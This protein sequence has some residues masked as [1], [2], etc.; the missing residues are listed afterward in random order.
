MKADVLITLLVI[1]I[2]VV[3]GFLGVFIIGQVFGSDIERYFQST[4]TGCGRE[5]QECCPQKWCDAGLEC[6]E[7]NIC[8]EKFGYEAGPSNIYLIYNST[9]FFNSSQR[10]DFFYLKTGLGGEDCSNAINCINCTK[11][12]HFSNAL[13]CT[14]CDYCNITDNTCED[15]FVCDSAEGGN[16]QELFDCYDC[17]GCNVDIS[18]YMADSCSQCSFCNG[19]NISTYENGLSCS[20]C[21]GCEPNVGDDCYFCYECGGSEYKVCEK[22]ERIAATTCEITSD[23]ELCQAAK[24]EVMLFDGGGEPIES[25][26][27]VPWETTYSFYT[28]VSNVL[29]NCP[30]TGDLKKFIAE[31]GRQKICEYENSNFVERYFESDDTAY[32]PADLIR[33]ITS[34]SITGENKKGILFNSCGPPPLPEEYIMGKCIDTDGGYNNLV[35]GTCKD[36]ST[37]INGCTDYCN[38]NAIVE[39]VCEFDD[40]IPLLPEPPCPAVEPLNPSCVD[41]ACVGALGTIYHNDPQIFGSS[42]TT[43]KTPEDDVPVNLQIVISDV[44]WNENSTNDCSYNVH[45]CSQEALAESED[46]AILG[47]WNLSAY[48]D[49][50]AYEVEINEWPPFDL[51]DPIFEDVQINV[52]AFRYRPTFKIYV[53]ANYDVQHIAKAIVAGLRDYMIYNSFNNKTVEFFCTNNNLHPNLETCVQNDVSVHLNDKV[54]WNLESFAST[55]DT[56]ASIPVYKNI[57]YNSTKTS[58]SNEEVPIQITFFAYTTNYSFNY[59]NENLSRK[60]LVSPVIVIGRNRAAAPTG[61]SFVWDCSNWDEGDKHDFY[62][63]TC[64]GDEPYAI[65]CVSENYYPTQSTDEGDYGEDLIQKIKIRNDESCVVRSRDTS[66]GNEQGRRVCVLCSNRTPSIVWGL[67][68]PYDQDWYTTTWEVG[69]PWYMSVESKECPSGHYPISCL[70]DIDELDPNRGDE[71]D[72]VVL[73]DLY[74]EDNKCKGTFRDLYGDGPW[75]NKGGYHW[76][77]IT[78]G[79]VCF[80]E[81][82]GTPK[83]TGYVSKDEGTGPSE[84]WPLTISGHPIQNFSSLECNAAEFP[85]SVFSRV[86]SSDAGAYTED[87]LQSTYLDGQRFN[88]SARDIGHCPWHSPWCDW[89]EQKRDVGVLC[90]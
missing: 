33:M 45:I 6:S 54:S 30:V 55:V 5:G 34:G 82:L 75:F 16:Y 74:L 59:N 85:V 36:E 66:G 78:L 44:L 84:I 23:Y 13:T 80:D 67:T 1:F 47:F 77:R 79:I 65:S 39:Y 48:F 32:V 56:L 38:G 50:N 69:E 14:D 72:E 64:S 20:Y 87:I 8:V 53:N 21:N 24:E 35:K 49:L 63:P 11:L 71:F 9:E 27:P 4:F 18:N 41:G 40:C 31:G 29:G 52:T 88:V 19:A 61:L 42:G 51:I 17:G 68:S 57:Y 83:W 15:C 86:D 73:T 58:Y 81:Y 10:E 89:T 28:T 25:F 70:A 26:L 7:I 76:F 43:P 60:I 2:I 46:D 62:S 3:V 12:Y 90:V 37:C 22:C